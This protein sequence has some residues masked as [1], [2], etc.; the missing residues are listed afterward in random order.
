MNFEEGKWLQLLEGWIVSCD[1]CIDLHRQVLVWGKD[2]DFRTSSIGLNDEA[3]SC[4]FVLPIHD[5]DRVFA[6]LEVHDR[7]SVSMLRGDGLVR[8]LVTIVIVNVEVVI[9]VPLGVGAGC[10]KES[11]AT[12]VDG[13]DHF[14]VFWN[15]HV[16][17]ETI[18]SSALLDEFLNGIVLPH[19][20][21]IRGHGVFESLGLHVEDSVVSCDKTDL[22]L[23]LIGPSRVL[24]VPWTTVELGTPWV[25]HFKQ[26]VID[27]IMVNLSSSN[28]GVQ[29]SCSE[30]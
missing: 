1:S 7:V 16:V 24:V 6:G 26:L 23:K 3:G 12:V 28:N 22:L 2:S 27:T 15:H 4:V 30:T 17:F 8:D 9:E 11:R 10:C 21:L 14:L 29:V 5:L 18:S 19:C 20:N 13:E 25:S